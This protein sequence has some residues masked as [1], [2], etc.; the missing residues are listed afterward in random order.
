M[1]SVTRACNA[2]PSPRHRRSPLSIFKPGQARL[3][4]TRPHQA[5]PAQRLLARLLIARSLAPSLAPRHRG[6]LLHLLKQVRGL[7][8]EVNV[9]LD[10]VACARADGRGAQGHAGERAGVSGLA[11]RARGHTCAVAVPVGARW[12]GGA[13]G[14]RPSCGSSP[15]ACHRIRRPARGAAERA[16]VRGKGERSASVAALHERVRASARTRA[17]A[18]AHAHTCALS[19]RRAA[20]RRAAPRRTRHAVHLVP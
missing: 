11:P 12:L 6:A 2:P 4:K 10:L 1:R 8:A 9:E 3:G 20:P 19:A 18:F 17:R 7:G 13:L 5:R 15:R 16:R 14:T